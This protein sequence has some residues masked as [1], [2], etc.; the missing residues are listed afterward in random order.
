MQHNSSNSIGVSGKDTLRQQKKPTN[1]CKSDFLIWLPAGCAPHPPPA[2]TTHSHT[3]IF[4][5]GV[6]GAEQTCYLLYATAASFFT[7][8]FAAFDFS[9]S[10]PS[11]SIC[12][13]I[14]L[15]QQL[16]PRHSSLALQLLIQL[17]VVVLLLLEVLLP[18][19]PLLLLLLLPSH[20]LG[21][22]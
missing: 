15:W 12:F 8:L 22:H 17:L 21:S 2:N 4:F 9:F 16:Q 5:F 18:L 6:P 13:G 3:P 20:S 1:P 19:P 7:I 14:Q 10:C 11:A